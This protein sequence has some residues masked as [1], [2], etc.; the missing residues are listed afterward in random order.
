MNIIHMLRSDAMA[1]VKAGMLKSRDR[2]RSRSR[3]V[4]R[5]LYDGL[6]LG[7]GLGL[8]LKGSGLETRSQEGLKSDRHLF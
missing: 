3:E 7:L 6:A 5:L 2:S 8:G 4:S 1:G